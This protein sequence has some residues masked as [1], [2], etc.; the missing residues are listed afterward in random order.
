M[1]TN[2][3]CGF[4]SSES[5]E[6]HYRDDNQAFI[7]DSLKEVRK[8]TAVESVRRMRGGSQAHLMRCSDGG[9]YVVKFQNN[10]QGCRILANDLLGSLLA[11]H[12]GLP[13]PQ[14]AIV[15]VGDGLVCGTEELVIEL[16]RGRIPCQAGLCFGSRYPVGA[17]GRIPAVFDLLPRKELLCARN[18]QD[19]A[20]MLVFDKW[21]SNTDGRQAVFMREPGVSSFHAM[22]IDQGNCFDG[23]AWAFRDAPLLGLYLDPSVYSECRNLGSFEPWLSRIEKEM[24]REFLA[25]AGEIIPREWYG[26]DVTALNHLLD[27]LNARRSKVRDLLRSTL[28]TSPQAFPKADQSVSDR[29]SIARRMAAGA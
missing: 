20:G 19:F 29:G 12:L 1:S 10:P 8:I 21:T 7:A 16:K 15:E 22:M 26:G 18:L 6:N 27:D 13:V 4:L 5:A 25:F 9:Y 17:D 3:S 24:N 28:A 14:I 2:G 11:Q 23:E